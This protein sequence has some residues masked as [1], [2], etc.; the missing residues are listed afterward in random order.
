MEAD[1][2]EKVTFYLT[3]KMSG[4]SLETIEG[5]GLSPALFSS[6][7]DLTKLRYDFPLVLI[8][9][10]EGGGFAEPL[11]GLIDTVLGRIAHGKEGDRIRQHVLR[12]EEAIRKLMANGASGTLSVLWDKAAKPLTASGDLVADSLSLARANLTI[13]GYL[14]NC[15]AAMPYRLLSHAWAITQNDKAR[16]FGREL[17]ALML[18]L[19]DILKA[20]FV[21]SNAGKS[22]E[23]LKASFGSGP[24]D[25]FDFGVMSRMLKKSASRV[26]LSRIRRHRIES[27][28]SV[29]KSQQFFP[30]SSAASG[31]PYSFAYNS[32][33][34]AL[35]A[36]RERLPKAISLAK[37]VAIAELE[38]KGEYKE[39]IHDA[40]FESFGD[41]GLDAKDLALFPDYLVHLNGDHLSASEQG[42]LNEILLADLPVK[43]LVQTDD[44]IDASPVGKGHLAFAL[45]SRRLASM[46][47]GMNDVFM[48]QSPA[49]NL[50]RLSRQIQAGL[51]FAG[52]ALFS[53]FSGASGEASGCPSYLIAA[54][55]MESRIFPAFVFDPS[56]GPDWASRFSLT[57][58]PQ[59]ELDWPLQDFQYEDAQSQ[60]VSAKVPFTL[61]D[62][63][64]SD[65]RYA[66]HFASVPR[67]KW[68]GALAPVDEIMVRE[69]NGNIDRIPSLLMVDA[70]NTLQKVIV[71][72]KLIRAARRCQSQWHSLQE[73]GGIHNSHA[74]RLL[75]R[76]RQAWEERL[77]Q[78]PAA[79]AQAAV[80]ELATASTLA[81]VESAVEQTPERS[82]D[83]AYIET[84]RCSTCNECTQ[85]NNKM[86]AYDGNQQAYVKDVTAGTYAQLVEAAESCQVSVIHP[87]KPRNPGEPGLAGL[88]ER[89]EAFL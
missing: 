85:I 35:K 81:A 82:P 33:S 55:A 48:L 80:P 10:P 79:P 52:P 9:K 84:A 58:N 21:N 17:D 1:L 89:A 53:V 39:S 25:Q 68:N 61:I 44:V 78:P 41:S 16:K 50:L 40:L 32:C 73:L 18:K 57:D 36:Y 2:Q 29:L 87:G 65:P 72:E 38:I 64:A 75:A 42:Q 67:E 31:S 49:S 3:G 6:Y 86:F 59:P 19:S 14:L 13:D 56:A 23:Q 83:E 15:D 24:M 47:M 34:S 37:A 11:S 69:S 51:D 20:D 76:E 5:V 71:D 66:R 27:L 62:F 46:A 12:L 70:N 7:R 30:A 77:A 28:L 60:T 74:E 43:I 4:A 88:L 22:A 26:R 54:A 8:V 45:S 63:V